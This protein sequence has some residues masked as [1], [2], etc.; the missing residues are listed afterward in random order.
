MLVNVG[1]EPIAP[2][3]ADAFLRTVDPLF[4]LK[5]V[6]GG[7]Y[8]FSYWAIMR[9][10]EERDPRRERIQRGELPASADADVFHFLPAD[11]PAEQ[12]EGYVLRFFQRSV[13]KP[14]EA[15]QAA[16]STEKHNAG[17][18]ADAIAA[19]KEE[20]I[21]RTIRMDTHERELAAGA[22]TAH[23][24]VTVGVD[25]KPDLINDPQPKHTPQ[26]PDFKNRRKN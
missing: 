14:K 24:M 6:N 9:R 15:A 21:D 4:F 22:T 17:V 1:G 10:W 11:C 13:D 5:W 7:K 16:E 26:R 3:S 18:R 12:V 8:A 25:L 19:L 2:A 23:P 20:V